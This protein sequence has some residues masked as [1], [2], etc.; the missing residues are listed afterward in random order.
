MSSLVRVL[1]RIM[2][3]DIEPGE[4]FII[5]PSLSIEIIEAEPLCIKVKIAG[6]TKVYRQ[7][8]PNLTFS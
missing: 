1:Q 8:P 6:K 7:S 2:L 5:T 4:R 3:G